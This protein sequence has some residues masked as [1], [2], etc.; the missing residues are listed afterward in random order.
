MDVVILVNGE[1]KTSR[2]TLKAWSE[3]IIKRLSELEGVE[4]VKQAGTGGYY[5]HAVDLKTTE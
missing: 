5:S 2:N 3:L 4:D 1:V